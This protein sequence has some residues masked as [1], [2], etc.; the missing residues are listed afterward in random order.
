M[1]PFTGFTEQFERILNLFR[2]NGHPYR[3]AVT[4]EH[5]GVVL[6][7]NRIARHG[8]G[9]SRSP[10]SGQR[11][12]AGDHNATFLL[13]VHRHVRELHLLA[14]GLHVTTSQFLKKETGKRAWHHGLLSPSID[15]EFT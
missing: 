6:N 10:P 9:S 1:D 15:R 3:L 7:A 2:A 8:W 5:D 13:T 14:V 4:G 12:V 11:Q